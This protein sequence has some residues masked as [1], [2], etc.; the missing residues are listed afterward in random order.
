MRELA[1]GE[2]R[3]K[4]AWEWQASMLWERSE[5]RLVR[6]FASDALSRFADER[7]Y[8]GVVGYM[9]WLEG[10]PARVTAH[11]SRR[12]LPACKGERPKN[13]H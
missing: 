7:H 12:S 8:P 1:E 13:P 2:D 11:F 6:L 9:D 5:E 3:Q 4:E 10:K